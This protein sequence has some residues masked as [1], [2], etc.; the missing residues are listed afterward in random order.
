MVMGTADGAFQAAKA[1]RIQS[2]RN[3]NSDGVQVPRIILPPLDLLEIFISN[4]ERAL[5]DKA[6]IVIGS[7]ERYFR[8]MA[9][10]KAAMDSTL[11][12][13]LDERTWTFADDFKPMEGVAYYGHADLA[14][15]SDRAAIAMGHASDF[16]KAEGGERPV[17][18][19]DFIGQIKPEEIEGGEIKL[20]SVLQLIVSLARK[21]FP[22]RLWT[23]DRFQSVHSMQVL[24]DN[25]GIRVANLSID[26]CASVV[27]VDNTAVGFSKHTT[28][29]RYLVAYDTAKMAFNE[30]RVKMP[31]HPAIVE[32]F[33]A[34]EYYAKEN[35][36]RTLRGRHDDVLQAVLGVI[37]NVTV[38]ESQSFEW[39]KDDV[40]YDEKVHGDR[41][42]DDKGYV[43]FEMEAIDLTRQN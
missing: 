20:D 33:E 31:A 34:A 27:E 38:N 3:D 23:Y 10:V 6:N 19:I 37:L 41:F 13:P 2:T 21:D 29:Q 35:K 17:I 5:R 15:T 1:K 32:E 7:I 25:W 36:I 42:Y 26:R 8:N 28:E 12:N 14:V 30:G 9:A 39:V 4:P 43:P 16:V 11:V 18:T 40:L 24:R 22:I